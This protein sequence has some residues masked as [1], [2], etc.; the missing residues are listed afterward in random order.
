ML[1]RL[2]VNPTRCALTV[3]AALF[4]PVGVRSQGGPPMLT[5]DPGT[6]GSRSWEI[7][8]GWNRQ[9]L[10]GSTIHW[11]PLID[12][13]YGVG[14]RVELTY[15]VPVGLV[16]GGAA[17]QAGIGNSEVSIKWRFLDVDSS[18]QVSIYP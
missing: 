3:V 2:A 6:P 1:A 18:W 5:D 15:T 8:L 17:A 13:N 4:I 9:Q 7:N 16:T 11:L 10:P 12:A 14:D